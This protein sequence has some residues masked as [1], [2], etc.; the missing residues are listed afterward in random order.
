MQKKEQ[1]LR[2]KFLR[3]IDCISGIYV[4]F[5]YF[6]I[7][8]DDLAVQTYILHGT[9]PGCISAWVFRQ[10]FHLQNQKT[11]K[12]KWV[13]PIYSLYPKHDRVSLSSETKLS[14]VLLLQVRSADTGATTNTATQS[15]VRS[16]TPAA[17]TEHQRSK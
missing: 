17:A 4:K 2:S 6:P 8:T 13:N 9:L 5:S 7:L 14:S 15:M 11:K 3:C 16:R 1:Y 12:V 10:L